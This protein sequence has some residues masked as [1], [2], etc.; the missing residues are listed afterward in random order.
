[1]QA[2]GPNIAFPFFVCAA[3]LFFIVACIILSFAHAQSDV[4]LWYVYGGISLFI[5]LC[6]FGIGILAKCNPA[7]FARVFD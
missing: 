2:F 4:S 5:G 1:M 3:S 6:M 7:M